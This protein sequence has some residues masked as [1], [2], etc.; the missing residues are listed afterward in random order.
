MIIHLRLMKHSRTCLR[1][2]VEVRKMTDLVVVAVPGVVLVGLVDRGVRVIQMMVS[3]KKYFI[4]FLVTIILLAVGI[5]LLIS[6]KALVDKDTPPIDTESSSDSLLK[7]PM[8]IEAEAKF[9]AGDFERAISIYKEILPTLSLLGE[10][11]AVRFRLAVAQTRQE[12]LEAIKNL[13]TVAADEGA[14][15][16]QRA[17]AVERLGLMFYRSSDPNLIPVIFSGEPYESFYVEKNTLLALRR[18]FEYASSIFRPLAISELRAADIYLTELINA[19]GTTEYDGLLG[20]Y[21]PIIETRISNANNDIELIKQSIA[22]STVPEALVLKA[23]VYAKLNELGL[24]YEAEPIFKE[25]LS[26]ALNANSGVSNVKVYYALFLQQYE[27]SRVDDIA[28]NLETLVAGISNYPAFETMFTNER[29]NV[30]GFK[31]V[32]VSLANT[33][34]D[35]KNLLITL[36]WQEEDFK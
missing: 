25:A 3:M 32:M 8:F 11:G 19:K 34:T 20:E 4:I 6:S 14:L 31:P 26:E 36:G 21:L 29:N 27:P 5:F 28:K 12:P 7:N 23:R 10:D 33:N 35:F 2:G 30:L 15:K 16:I 13:K 1:K 22:S 17:Y 24:N 18:L 9:K